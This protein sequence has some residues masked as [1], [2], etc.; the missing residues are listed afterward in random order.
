MEV[1]RVVWQREEQHPANGLGLRYLG[2]KFALAWAEASQTVGLGLFS[3]V[4][5]KKDRSWGPGKIPVCFIWS[6]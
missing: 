3:S 5:E 1:R 4:P 2:C 6:Y